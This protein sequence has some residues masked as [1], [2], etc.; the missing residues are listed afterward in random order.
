MHLKLRS[1]CSIIVDDRSL[2]ACDHERLSRLCIVNLLQKVVLD[3]ED[4]LT[5]NAPSIYRLTT[6]SSID[7]ISLIFS[8]SS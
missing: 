5:N 2:P 6:S 7:F 8:L 3:D 1:L 4:A